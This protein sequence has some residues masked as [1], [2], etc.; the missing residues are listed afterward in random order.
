MARLTESAEVREEIVRALGDDSA[1]DRRAAKM[2]SFPSSM[3]LSFL[4]GTDV[5]SLE[6]VIRWGDYRRVEAAMRLA[7]A[8]GALAAA[9]KQ[10][11]SRDSWQGRS[12]MPGVD[13]MQR[14][15]GVAALRIAEGMSS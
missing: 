2:G 1:E 5:D 3:E 7:H 14:P 9:R 4:V 8:S 13:G 11:N 6:A 10:R 12:R 15:V